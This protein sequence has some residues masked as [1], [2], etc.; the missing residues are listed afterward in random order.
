MAE[1]HGQ[2]PWVNEYPQLSMTMVLKLIQEQKDLINDGES[3]M[4]APS[5]EISNQFLNELNILNAFLSFLK[6]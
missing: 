1:F 2:Y 5:S 4:A 3:I 6:L